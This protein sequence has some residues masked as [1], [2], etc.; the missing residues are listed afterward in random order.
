LRSW[1]GRNCRKSEVADALGVLSGGGGDR[2]YCL[3]ELLPL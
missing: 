1:I 2:V 3:R